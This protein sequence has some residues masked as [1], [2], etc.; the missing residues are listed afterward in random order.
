MKPTVF[1]IGG[2]LAGLSAGLYL[3]KNG[4]QVTLM[5]KK[6]FPFHR[7]CGEYI[8]NE[9]LPFLRTLGINP[10]DYGASTIQDLEVSSNQGRIHSQRLDLGGFGISRYTLDEVL[11][12]ELVRAGAEVILEEK[13]TTVYW[14]SSQFFL[15]DSKGKEYRADFVLGA[16]GKRSNLDQSLHRQFFKQ[17]SPFLGVKYHIHFDM[18]KNLIQLHNFTLGYA[19][20]SAI[21][22][23][24]F[25]FCYLSHSSNLKKYVTIPEMESVVL[26][27]NPFLKRIFEEA[28]FL[29]EKPQVIHEISF[30]QKTNVQ[31]HILFCGDAAG[32]ISPLCGNG[33]AMAIH[34]GKLAG[35][36]ILQ[37][38]E[39]YKNPLGRS[40]LEKNYSKKWDAYFKNRLWV[41][42][43][44]QN[45]FGNDFLTHQALGLLNNL[46]V[47]SHLLIKSSH[48]KV[49]E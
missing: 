44:I 2:G 14:N 21:E 12:N 31:D 6:K 16:F 11:Y 40:L 20:I 35:D 25:C 43:Q 46:P 4:I 39:G 15:M 1:I 42:R 18:P 49:I 3:S 48:G 22:N 30:Q 36:C 5:E 29:W 19:G 17:R 34:S 41:G 45:L 8:S 33:M 10:F 32:L 28:T 37:A 47:V 9:V 23:N 13:I 38:G 26:K 7:V 27:K 24:S